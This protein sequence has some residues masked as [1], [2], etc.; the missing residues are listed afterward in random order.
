MAVVVIPRRI[1]GNGAAV[2]AMTFL[3]S[4]LAQAR[5]VELLQDR[6]TPSGTDLRYFVPIGITL[7]GTQPVWPKAIHLPASLKQT[8]T[9]VLLTCTTSLACSTSCERCSA[10]HA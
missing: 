1:T 8:S 7:V 4:Q 2:L 5:P 3:L 10:S 9:H 6:D